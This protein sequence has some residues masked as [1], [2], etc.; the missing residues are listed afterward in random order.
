MSSLP[1][2]PSASAIPA[3]LTPDL[4]AAVEFAKAEKSPATRKAYGTDFRL[5]RAWCDEKQA[6]ALPAFPETVAAY[7]AH[8]V[9]AGAKAS[10]LSRRLAAIR[11]AHKLASLP[12]PIRRRSALVRRASDRRNGFGEGGLSG[13]PKSLRPRRSGAEACAER[14]EEKA[15]GI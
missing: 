11:Y 12:T 13:R 4:A 9:E 5:F 3:A 1:A 14:P 10:T 15:K 6:G 8:G 2:L 7:L